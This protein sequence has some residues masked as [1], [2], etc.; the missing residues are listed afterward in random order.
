MPKLETITP[1]RCHGYH[2]CKETQLYCHHP[3]WLVQCEVTMTSGDLLARASDALMHTL[4]GGPLD[5]AANN[6]FTAILKTV[7]ITIATAIHR[8]QYNSAWTSCLVAGERAA[9]LRSVQ[10]LSSEQTVNGIGFP[11]ALYGLD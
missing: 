11:I 10:R 2:I 5:A 1:L 3:C 9:E 4:T 7:R 8:V 6:R